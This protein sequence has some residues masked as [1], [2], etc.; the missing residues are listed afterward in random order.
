[1]AQ[2]GQLQVGQLYLG[3][4]RNGLPV[5]SQPGGIGTPVFPQ[6]PTIFPWNGQREDTHDQYEWPAAYSS[7]YV[8]GCGHPSNCLEIYSYFDK[9]ADEIMALICC[10]QC[11]YINEIMPYTQ[12]QSYLETPLVVT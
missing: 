4:N 11:S 8:L 2:P 3:F 7:L 10:G 5:W 1:M 12:Y 6:L 9:Y